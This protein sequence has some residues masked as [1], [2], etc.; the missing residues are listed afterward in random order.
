VSFKAK[1]VAALKHDNLCIVGGFRVEQVPLRVTAH[2]R[3]WDT[4]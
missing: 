4:R 3:C 1:V 2:G